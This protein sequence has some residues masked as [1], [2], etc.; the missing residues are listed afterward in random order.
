M[1]SQGPN[2]PTA[3]TGNTNTVFAGTKV[4]TN[5][6]NILAV[7]SSRAIVIQTLA[8]TVTT[9]D[10]IATGFGFSIPAGAT[11]NGIQVDMDQLSS[12]DGTLDVGAK[13][14]KAGA[15][16]GTSQTATGSNWSS[17]GGTATYGGSTN[18]WGTTWTA[19]DINSSNF[20]F[21]IAAS[22]AAAGG[23]GGSEAAESDWVKITVFY[24]PAPA[25]TTAK[26]LMAF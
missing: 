18:L 6:T 19:P 1:A 7:D 10:L 8:G 12:N 11:I 3:A 9:D 24:T 2:L 5:P 22:I 25:G 17:L 13:L 20:G 16:V 14:L 23:T 21:V 4:W 26:F 15:A